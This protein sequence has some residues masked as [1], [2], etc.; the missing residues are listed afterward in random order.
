MLT[1]P[2]HYA[3]LISTYHSA[4]DPSSP[5]GALMVDSKQAAETKSVGELGQMELDLFKKV[6]SQLLERVSYAKE[7]L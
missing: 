6:L 5:F 2:Q 4:P 7:C 1:D 3:K